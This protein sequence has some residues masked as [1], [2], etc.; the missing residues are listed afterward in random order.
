LIVR[1]P[2]SWRDPSGFVYRRDGRLLR[3]VNRSFAGHW[4][5][6]GESGFLDELVA[7]RWLIPYT[8]VSTSLAADPALAH[9]VIAP[10]EIRFVSR[11][12]EWTF[13]QLRDA[14][15]LTLD[16]QRLALERGFTLKDASA[17]NIQFHDG[18]PVLID[19]LSLEI[20][21]PDAPWA[22]YRQFCEHFL[23]PLALMAYRDVRLARL[24]MSYIDGI[25]LDLVS[26][27]LP[28]RTLGRFGL[29]GHIHLHARA[30]GRFRKA[31]ARRVGSSGAPSASNEP[32][33][34]GGMTDLRRAALVDS[35]RSAV[36]KLRWEPRRSGWAAYTDET[37][38]SP[39]GARSKER[40]V[41]DMLTASAGSLVWDLGAN[42]GR[43]SRI[44]AGLGKRVVAFDSDAGA[45]ELHYRAVRA[46][47]LTTILPLVVDV[48]S[49]TPAVGWGGIERP[50]LGDRA[51]ADVA[52]ALALVHHLAI[53]R[54]VPLPAI[55][56]W[57]AGLAREAI[58][59]F[60]PLGDPMADGLVAS[61]ATP[62]RDYTI[63]A[64]RDAMRA[65]WDVV[66]ERPIEDSQ[67]V[68]FHLRRPERGD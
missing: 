45:A 7:R 16:I 50:S 54:N 20:A 13:G 11:P 2:A 35:L 67:R 57:L 56:A 68:L 52:L 21:E 19:T 14:A 4:D 23:G 9:A 3:Q 60:V 38:Y 5:R 53:T 12:V 10:D 25:P 65:S 26:R 36:S 29:L 43:F 66:G 30:Q 33:S 40:I 61:K 32:A 39:V 51:N 64:F 8:P 47:G 27:L 22:A 63:E 59:E 15:L 42:T 44:A 1:D 41:S 62:V 28:R 6:L 55:G 34:G 31:G 58:V 18:A 48:A 17:F 24:R 37:S 46:A 49:P